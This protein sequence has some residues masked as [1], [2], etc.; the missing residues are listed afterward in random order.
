MPRILIVDDSAADRGL[1]GSI[2]KDL[3]HLELDY[4]NDGK[5]ALEKINQS[6]PDLVLTDLVMPHLNG[7][8]LVKAVRQLDAAIPVVLM[9]SK[10][11]AKIATDALVAGA[12]SYVPKSELVNSL[13]E[14][15]DHVLAISAPVRGHNRLMESLT[16]RRVVF[17][18]PNSSTHIASLISFVQDQVAY[19][20]LCDESERIR[21]GVALEEALSNAMY[22][23]NLEADSCLKEHDAAA[24]DRLVQQRRREAPYCERRILV[25]ISMSS[26]EA[27][28]VIRDQ[29]PGFDPSSLPDP[30]DPE[31]LDRLCGR[32]VLLMRTFMDDVQFSARGNEVTMIKRRQASEPAAAS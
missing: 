11:S 20:G 32:G 16:R 12:A 9:T 10:G 23:G 2:L 26:E 3:P 21:L 27:V 8:E 22:H 30:T 19:L 7:L 4:A 29:G 15:V 18:L 6:I 5:V 28:V 24:F 1:V 25:E 17:E 13:T 31:N 14:T